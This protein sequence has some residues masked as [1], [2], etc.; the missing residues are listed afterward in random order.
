MKKSF[1]LFLIALTLAAT[2]LVASQLSSRAGAPAATI[3]QLRGD[4]PRDVR[5][6][7]DR[8]VRL[9]KRVFHVG[10]NADGMTPPKP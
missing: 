3:Q 6:P 7:L 10:T 4:E 2:S 8:I 5:D 1:S 9:L